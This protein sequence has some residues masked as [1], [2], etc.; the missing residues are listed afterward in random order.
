MPLKGLI[1]LLGDSV[2]DR[3]SAAQAGEVPCPRR[4]GFLKLAAASAGGLVAGPALAKIT[5]M[6]QRER[7]VSLYNTHTGESIRLVYWA[8]G[9]GYLNLSIKEISWL[10]RDRR[11]NEME[12]VDPKLLD[13]L[14]GLQL[15]L[16]PGKQLHV[17]SGYRSPET[18]AALRQKSRKVAKHSYHMLGKAVD[19]R[20]PGISVGQL[21]RAAVD[22]GVGGV[23]Y[24]PRAGFI[25]LDTGPVRYWS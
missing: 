15:K 18:N 25:H 17:L 14:Y 16:G 13:A 10:M 3:Q 19:I 9:D 4:R 7:A 24:Y 11:T 5:P 20:V 21:R 2:H 22:L 12:M 1:R 23:G 6:S 8:P